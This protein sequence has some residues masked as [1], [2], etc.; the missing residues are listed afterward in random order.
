MKQLIIHAGIQRTGTTTL[1]S[2]LATH[3]DAL[4]RQGLH[5]AVASRTS[6][7][8]ELGW[9]LRRGEVDA[10]A[11]AAWI[12]RESRP[13]CNRTLLSAEV[14]CTLRNLSFLD[15]AR[16][17]H[18]VVAVFY[19]RRQDEWLSSW[20]NVNVKL[21]PFRDLARMGPEEFL[22]QR[23]RFHWLRYAG[24]L[25]TWAAAIG[26]DNLRVRV[27]EPA[28][29]SDVVADFLA[30]IGASSLPPAR[31]RSNVSLAADQIAFLRALNPSRPA[32]RKISRALAAILSDAPVTVFSPETRRAILADY[33]SDNAAAARRHL[34]RADGRLFLNDTV[35]D[36]APWYRG[37]VWSDPERLRR[38]VDAAIA[39][40]DGE[41]AAAAP[42]VRRK[43]PQV[44]IK[45]G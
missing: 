13:D 9:A 41:A 20:Y 38:Y 22:G 36:D 12:A 42:P 1:Q 43:T 39:A 33:A 29:V 2:Y 37:D 25:D 28:Q 3:A 6:N 31:A 23:G 40:L 35:P 4:R 17:E 11:F 7:H 19:L 18:D 45:T 16:K 10:A 27:V 26:A 15:E 14:F 21:G 30:I 34:R 5:Y 24:M 44:R 8:Q 32:R